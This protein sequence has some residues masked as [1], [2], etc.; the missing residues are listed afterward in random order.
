MTNPINTTTPAVAIHA[1]SPS[2]SDS[3]AAT[4]STA[5]NAMKMPTVVR[6]SRTARSLVVGAAA[7]EEN[8]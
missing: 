6:A 5:R 8:R 4:A 1:H 3:V 7:R 2:Q